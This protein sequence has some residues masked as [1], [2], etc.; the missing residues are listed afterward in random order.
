VGSLDT[1]GGLESGEVVTLHAALE[2]LALASAADVYEWSAFEA[3]D[4]QDITELDVDV[5]N[6]KFTM[7][8][9]WGGARTMVMTDHRHGAA[10]RR[11]ILEADLDGGI[12]ISLLSFH[13]SDYARPGL[14]HSHRDVHPFFREVAGHSDLFSKQCRSHVPDPC[15]ITSSGRPSFHDSSLPAMGRSRF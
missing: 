15:V 13:L 5:V 7:M 10:T 6:S 11:N 12:A 3:L 14:N 2:S 9:L 1:V 4:S 8:T